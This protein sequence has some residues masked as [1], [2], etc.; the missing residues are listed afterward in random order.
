MT[1]DAASLPMSIPGQPPPSPALQQALELLAAGKGEEAEDVVRSAAKQAKARHGSGSHPLAM[2][3]ADMA[4]LHYR[5]GDHKKAASEFRHAAD[6]PVPT[7]APARRDRLAFMFGFAACLDA[8]GKPGEAEKV[9]RQ[10]ASFARN[11]HGPTAPGYAVALEPLAAIL[12]RT[13]N[14]GEAARLMDEA[15]DILWKHGDPQ[16]A[17]AIPTRAEAL[18]AVGRTDN[19][20][21]ELADL[22]DELVVETVSHVIGRS[23]RGDGTRVRQV[24]ADLLRFVDRRFGDGHPATAD[25]LAAIAHHEAALGE[26]GDPKVRASA[27]RRAV[28]SFAVRRV[29]G[30]LLANLEVGF[31]N[32]GTIHVVPHLSRDPAPDELAG[33]EVVLTQAVDDLYHRTTRKP[34]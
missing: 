22:P 25:T 11:L 30:G 15:F 13:G 14:G 20:F 6:G 28:W 21:H 7:G 19:A 2:A 8:M 9:Y 1:P 5:T 29:P 33:L 26:E 32:G 31:E 23:G 12:L 17:A 10:C 34:D 3:Y 18:K 4:R 16:I 27:A 24:L